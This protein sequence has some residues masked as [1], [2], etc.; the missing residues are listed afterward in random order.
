MIKVKK[1]LFSLLLFVLIQINLSGE[2]YKIDP[3]QNCIFLNDNEKITEKTLK[4]NLDLVADYE[5][6]LFG[7]AYLSDQRD[8]EADPFP[9]VV[10]FYCTNAQDGYATEYSLLKPGDILHFV[11]PSTNPDD[12]FLLA[13][14]LDYWPG[15]LNTGQY[16]LSIT[17]K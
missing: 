3:V 17:K 10:L 15:S 12:V 4:V 7:S 13:F 8:A 5:I 16:T 9:G 6:Q 14:L 2:D 1:F 11:T